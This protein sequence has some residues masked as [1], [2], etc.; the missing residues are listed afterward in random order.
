MEIVKIIGIAFV[1]SICSILIKSTKP[2]LSFAVITAGVLVILMQIFSNISKISNVF[3]E[4]TSLTGIE[5]EL[6]K[7]LLKLVSIGYLTE[8]S[9]GILIDFGNVSLA[10]KVVLGGKLT[11]VLLSLPV[12]KTLL[13]LMQ[14]FLK[15]I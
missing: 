9:A 15:I 10:D 3:I 1:T 5:N 14:G 8:I 11:I 7:L 4:I 12:I 2:E 6:L 13:N